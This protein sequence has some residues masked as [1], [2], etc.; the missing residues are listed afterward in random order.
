MVH[1][2]VVCLVVKSLN[3]VSLRVTLFLIQ[4]LLLLNV[5]YL[6]I[7]LTRYWSLS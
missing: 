3:R 1:F 2:T 7:M 4:R 5:N 6:V